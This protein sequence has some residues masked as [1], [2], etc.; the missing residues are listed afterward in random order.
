MLLEELDRLEVLERDDEV[1]EERLDV[2]EPEERELVDVPVE[3]LESSEDRG[4]SPPRSSPGSVRLARGVRPPWSSIPAVVAPGVAV[5]DAVLRAA[6]WVTATDW[7]NDSL[8]SSPRVAGTTAAVAASR[9]ARR[10]MMRP[11]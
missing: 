8:P 2:L 7:A 4:R 11:F 10:F 9:S 3:E 5:A 6:G 1:P